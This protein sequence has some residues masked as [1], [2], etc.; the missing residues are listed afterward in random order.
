MRAEAE[1]WDSLTAS[2]RFTPADSFLIPVCPRKNTGQPPANL[3]QNRQ[4]LPGCLKMIS[5]PKAFANVVFLA[6]ARD[7]GVEQ[8]DK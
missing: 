8:Q 1:T 7:K 3:L 6:A 5:T 4:L 2:S